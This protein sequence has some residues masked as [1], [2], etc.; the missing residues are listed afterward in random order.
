MTSRMQ[1]MLA[2]SLL[3]LAS[4]AQ[5]TS[6]R[7]TVPGPHTAKNTAIGWDM[8]GQGEVAAQ[9]LDGQLG[10]PYVGVLY[11]HDNRINLAKRAGKPLSYSA[12][13]GLNDNGQVVGEARAS[14][15]GHILP[16]LYEHGQLSLLPLPE[17]ADGGISRINR[18]GEMIGWVVLPGADEFIAMRMWQG[19]MTVLPGLA[20][21]AGAAVAINDAGLIVGSSRG[22]SDE[23][24]PVLWRHGR[25]QRLS[26]DEHM[27]GAAAD[28][29]NQGHIVGTLGPRHGLHHAHL[30]RDGLSIDLDNNPIASSQAMSINDQDQIVGLR[31]L[32]NRYG[33]FVQQAGEMQW[34][35][36]LIVPEQQGQWNIYGVYRINNAG[37]ILAFGFSQTEGLQPL[38][39]TPET[40]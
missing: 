4:L 15:D 30:W 35:D 38:V 28:V 6:Y 23:G 12:A 18:R 2:C 17:G 16:I 22:G 9:F 1:S 14:A 21:R 5:A 32:D 34:L 10:A 33:V 31:A 24:V 39:L 19:Q 20:G 7:I 40:P 36:D 11:R 26:P 37:Q 13:R 29:N 3:L 25:V 27:V 8:N